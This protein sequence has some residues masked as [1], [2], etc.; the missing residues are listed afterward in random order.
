MI[1]VPPKNFDTLYLKLSQIGEVSRKQITKKD[2]TNEY[3]ELHAKK[4]SL[5]KARN[6]LLALKNKGGKIEEYMNLENRILEIERQLQDLGVS[7]GDFDDE[8]EFCTVKFSL[9]ETQQTNISLFHRIKVALDWTVKTY[10]KLSF[11]I[12]FIS[13]I[14]Y[15][16]LLA[17]DKFKIIQKL[18]SK[19]HAS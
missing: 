13:G 14:I 16:I 1:G 9:H 18:L 19:I 3:K 17:I 7:L 10:L 6:S 12:L 2:K 15:L 5:E 11:T 4:N 8:N